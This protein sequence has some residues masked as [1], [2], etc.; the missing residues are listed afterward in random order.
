MIILDLDP[1]FISKYSY[2]NDLTELRAQSNKLQI[3]Q[4]RQSNIFLKDQERKISTFSSKKA[5][6]IETSS[7]AKRIRASNFTEIEK[8]LY[9]WFSDCKSK[10][11]I[12]VNGRCIQEQAIK[13]VGLINEKQFKASSGWLTNVNN[14]SCQYD[15]SSATN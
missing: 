6:A 12:T 7:K 2:L 8:H 10:N 14:F 11:T 9:S 4:N 13:I 3:I 15:F 5:N 1:V